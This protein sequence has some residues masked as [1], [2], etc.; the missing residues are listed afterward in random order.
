MNTVPIARG[1]WWSRNWKWFVPLASAALLALLAAVVFGLMSLVFGVIKS[2]EPTRDAIQRARQDTR[3]VE[4]LG[5]PVEAG[6]F[7]MGEIQTTGASG[8]ANLAIPLRGSH[9]SGTLYVQAEKRLGEWEYQTLML[10]LEDSGQR[11]DLH[12]DDASA[13]SGN[14]QPPSQ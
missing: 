3:V 7:V 14:D 9:A 10:K 1:N 11:I 5:P 13:P 2:S 8:K 12:T 6:F 4:A